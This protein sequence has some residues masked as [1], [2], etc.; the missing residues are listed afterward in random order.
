[1]SLIFS[2]P[3]NNN[4]NNNNNSITNKTNTPKIYIKIKLERILPSCYK[5]I[6]NKQTNKHQLTKRMN[7]KENGKCEKYK[8]I[9]I[10][11]IIIKIIN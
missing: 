10:I 1:M 9:K 7:L 5:N 4:N 3:Q 8:Q 2:C 6:Y 11:I